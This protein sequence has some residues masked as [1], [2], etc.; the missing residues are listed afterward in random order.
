MIVPEARDE[1]RCRRPMAQL[2]PKR[3]FFQHFEK[4]ERL[5]NHCHVIGAS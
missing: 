4:V 3:V 1:R 5:F 2:A